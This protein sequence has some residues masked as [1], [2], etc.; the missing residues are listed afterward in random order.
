MLAFSGPALAH[1]ESV[2]DAAA[3]PV[4]GGSQFAP[5]PPNTCASQ[6]DRFYGS[7]PGVYAYWALCE[8]GSNPMIHD[9]TGPFDFDAVHCAWGKGALTGGAPGPVDD[10]ETAVSVSAGQPGL[11]VAQ[12]L[13]V[14]R[15]AGSLAAW[16]NSRTLSSGSAISV[17]LA[18]GAIGGHSSV[19]LLITARDGTVCF[20]GEWQNT[21][22]PAFASEQNGSV[23]FPGSRCGYR[24][25]TW[26]RVVLT[27][28]SGAVSI[29]IDGM[30]AH[31]S[32]YT[33]ALDNA[34]FSYQLFITN[35]GIDMAAAKASLS[36]RTWT[37]AEVA[38]DYH[39]HW[40]T[41]PAGGVYVSAEPLG[42]IHR[43]V[44][45]Y[46][47]A[48]ANLASPPPVAAL[49]AGLQA[50]G[51]TAVRYANGFGGIDADREDW[52]GGPPCAS[53]AGAGIDKLTTA[54]SGNTLDAYMSSIAEPLKLHV[55]YTVNY[56]T[57]PPLCD[58]GG[59]PVTNGAAL[60]DY[61]NHQKHYRIKYWEIGNELYSRATEPDFHP[62]AHTGA[63]YG[64]YEPAFYQAMKSVDPEISI[65]IPVG[66]DV[67]YDWLANFT[68]PSLQGA[69]YDA[70][71]WHNYPIRDPI[72]DGA[73]LYQ[74]RVASNLIRTR[75]TLLSLQTMLLNAGKNPDSIWVTEW[76]GDVN[77]AEWSRQSMGAVMPL[78]AAAQLAEYMRAG[79]QYAAWW[80]QGKSAACMHYFYDGAGETAYNWW[81][82]GGLPLTYPEPVSA[83]TKVGLKLGDITPAARA[84]QLLSMSG[85]VTEGEHMLETLTDSQRAPWLLSYAATHG[86]SRAVLLINRDRDHPHSVPVQF[87]GHV[88][89]A[90]V[91][92]WT[93]GRTQ[94]DQTRLQNWSAQPVTGSVPY[95]EDSFRAD[96]PPWSINVFVIQQGQ[97]AR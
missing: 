87:A 51:V 23:S 37:P 70:I 96:L 43:D 4:P 11:K 24:P 50:A 69:K 6:Y 75:G 19:A 49:A 35:S 55:G 94:Y 48:N 86:S 21:S 72:T 77:G 81:Q 39:P 74:D 90:L 52:R 67:V 95:G 9:Y 14:N 46:G 1:R 5:P 54:S 28:G 29:Y 91:A 82:C 22:S 65:G 38:A 45:G 68:L 20:G 53:I 26:H 44:L 36:N 63:S 17:P 59:D 42:T 41:P 8:G 73:T 60:V 2:P 71:A 62:D 25:G 56:G 80:A 10:N 97:D 84:F 15:N 34:V 64:I 12:N 78:F 85:F 33:G 93:Y 66:T 92:T 30:P 89:G 57:N 3:S 27:W 83:E 88:P 61:A 40:I 79:V 13:P 76:N 16:L 31:T 18:I 32:R 47:D 7:E 58:A